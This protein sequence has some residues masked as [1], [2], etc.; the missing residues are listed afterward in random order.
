[1]KTFVVSLRTAKSRRVAAARQLEKC[2]LD[3]EFFAAVDGSCFSRY[4]NG[5]D[6]WQFRLNTRR[7]PLPGELGCYASHVALWRVCVDMAQPIVVLEDDF[8]LNPEFRDVIAELETLVSTFGYIRLEPSERRR[9]MFKRLQPD[10]YDVLRFNDR[11]LKYLSDPPLCMLAYAISPEAAASLLKASGTLSAPVD[12]FLQRTWEH[13]TPIFAL[14]PAIVRHADHAASSTIGDRSR[15][16]RNPYLLLR[17][18]IYKALG[19]VRRYK[20]DARQLRLLGLRHA[21]A[22]TFARQLTFNDQPK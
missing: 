3:F 7:D 6:R 18:L 16:S 12:K 21:H 13:E 22:D 9:S 1:V 19:E 5:F 10:S 8:E 11:I 15:K 2:G 4:V 20:F 17:R 14:S